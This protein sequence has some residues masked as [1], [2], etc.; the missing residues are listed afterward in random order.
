MKLLKL[1]LPHGRRL[2]VG[3]MN[4]GFICQSVAATHG[5][6]SCRPILKRKKIANLGDFFEFQKIQD[7]LSTAWGTPSNPIK[8]LARSVRQFSGEI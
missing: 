4:Y 5:R 8:I 2:E 7:K 6:Y 3:H 1:K